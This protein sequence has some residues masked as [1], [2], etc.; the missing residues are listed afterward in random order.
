[1]NLV[2]WVTVPFSARTEAISLSILVTDS[3]VGSLPHVF[4]GPTIEA[5]QPIDVC[6]DSHYKDGERKKSD[7]GGK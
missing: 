3:G 6:E 2:D 7:E 5:M 4:V 1:V